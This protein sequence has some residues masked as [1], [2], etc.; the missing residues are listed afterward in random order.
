MNMHVA[1][2]RSLPDIVE[3]YDQKHAA[4]TAALKS[5]ERSADELKMAATVAGTYGQVNIDVRGP[6]ESQL[7]LHLLKSAWFHVYDGLNMK[8]LSSPTD[9]RLWDQ[10]MSSPPPF[11]LDNIRGTFGKYI[12]DP[13]GQIL[14]GLAEV[15][16][17]LDQAYKSHD[18]VKVGVAGL[19]KRVVLR[20]FGNFS[21]HGRD[22]VQTILNALAAY[23]GRPLV[24]YPEL[25]ALLDDE[26]ALLETRT[27]EKPR[28]HGAP[29]LIPVHAR[30]VRLRRFQN[31]NGHLFFEKDTLKDINKALAE[32]YGD[33]LADTTDEKPTKKQ[34]S[35]A[36]S[37]D[38]QF[39][40]T[41]AKLATDIVD[42]LYQVKG[43]KFLEPSCG[44]G[45]LMDALRKAGAIV[46]G[47]EF[48][49]LRAAGCRAK[50]HPV[51]TANFLDTVATPTF[52]QVLMNP[53]FYGKHYAKH[54]LHAFEF[55]KPGGTLTAILPVTAI[56]HGLLDHLNPKWRHL[57][58]GSF[59][60]SG[61]NIN[62]VVVTIRK[63][64]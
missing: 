45:R 47:V 38:L 32:F 52:D 33:V 31:G 40:G 23:Q 7:A 36:V 6:Y 60:E 50:G 43:A 62:T 24:T 41:P 15:F 17:G 44:D 35:T 2:L 63:A 19:P 26:C 51:L 21:Y 8:T 5:F 58:V 48:D 54:V 49:A 14:R 9:K 30:G 42:D 12:L 22:A 55:L 25:D 4:L 56:E 29:D 3:E 64:A 37:K 27:I 13:R 16:C 34:A 46:T 57:P 28:R 1:K 59:S 11:T 53:P 20:G 18:V 61:T 10:A 39:Y